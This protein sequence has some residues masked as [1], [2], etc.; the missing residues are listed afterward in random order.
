M[1]WQESW[2]N[3]FIGEWKLQG[4]SLGLTE[5]IYEECPLGKIYVASQK[6]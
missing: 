3:S 2:Q 1:E 6:I 4:D 5:K